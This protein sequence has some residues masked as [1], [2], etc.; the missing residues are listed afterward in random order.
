MPTGIYLFIF[1]TIRSEK[2]TLG[3]FILRFCASTKQVNIWWKVS[4]NTGQKHFQNIIKHP[5]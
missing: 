5:R 2:L 1:N 3:A 4:I